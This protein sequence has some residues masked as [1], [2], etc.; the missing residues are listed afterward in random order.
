MKV[1]AA[2]MTMLPKMALASPPSEPGGGVICVNS[3][4]DSA[5]KP[6][7]NRTTRIHSRKIMPKAIAAIDRTRLMRLM[8]R[9]RR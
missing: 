7:P 9:R 6:L 3:V 1:A 4:G 5:A 2:T 8:R